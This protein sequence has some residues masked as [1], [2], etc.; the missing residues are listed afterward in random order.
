M[1]ATVTPETETMRLE[2]K[3]LDTCDGCATLA[4]SEQ[5]AG[6]CRR[7]N[8]RPAVDTSARHPR[9]RGREDRHA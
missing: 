7:C 2:F 1:R 9:R 8:P 6:L 5:L 3:S 4:K